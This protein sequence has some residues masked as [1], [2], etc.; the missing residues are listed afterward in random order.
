[1]LAPLLACALASVAAPESVPTFSARDVFELEYAADPRI[2]PDGT[3]IVYARTRLDIQT[4][5]PVSQLWMLE[6]RSG[7]HWPLTPVD[8]SCSS[9]R[10]S[11]DGKR[12]LYVANTGGG[13][14]LYLHWLERG[15]VSQ[16]TQLESSPG[17]LAWSPDGT[18]IAFSMEI[19]AP[20]APFVEMPKAPEG[21][22]WADP[23]R[24]IR[25]TQYK[26]DGSGLTEPAFRQLFV[27][28][29]EGG[30]PR[31][32]SEGPYDHT[33]VPSF[34]PDG[35]SLYCA[36][37]R[38][39]DAES[40]PLDSEIQRIDLIDGSIEALTSRLGPDDD[41]AVSPDGEWV[42][43]TGFDDAYQG[44]QIDQLYLMR[45]DGSE[46]RSLTHDL[47]RDVRGHRWSSSGDGI[48]FLYDDRG[49]T[50]LAFLEISGGKITLLADD[51]GGTSI[52][53]PYAS[54]SFTVSR[55][56]SAAYTRSTDQRPADVGLV[57]AGVQAKTLTDLNGDLLDNRRLGR[58]ES[59][60]FPSLADG[61]NIQGW[62]VF[63]PDY[64]PSESYPLILE[65]HGGPFANYG[66][67]FSAECQLYASAGYVVLYVN[68]RGSTSYGQEFGNLIH[69]AYPGEDYDDLMGGI[70][71]VI[72]NY[73]VD[74]ERLFV[75]G[76][77]GGG[78]LTSWIVGKT[79]RFQAAVVAKPV[80]HWTSF[81][82]TADFYTFFHRYWFPGP[83]WEHQEH[84]WKRSPLSLVGNV[85]TPT[86]LLT[87]EEDHRTPMSESEQYYQA[88]RLRGVESALVRVPGASHGIA[89]RP[90]HLIGKVL[91]ILKWFEIHDP[92][93]AEAR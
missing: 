12:L 13:A 80:I 79:D 65:I 82:L 69:H 92:E 78:V 59:I 40:Y 21:A 20:L 63:P 16:V 32:V 68:P 41:P 77:S 10:W 93:R 42:A 66:G 75:T 31:Q 86:M 24:L 8:S 43:Y 51:V 14:Q 25:H 30:T 26:Q 48:Y 91:H 90:S 87:G 64:D 72:A 67:R 23:P 1:M 88:L 5:R 55:N 74:P 58:V 70:E 9:P 19:P 34:S 84:Y 45:S 85:T 71:H 4:D 89:A 17:S 33:G 39:E 18:T 50:R 11:H 53:R 81:A 49:L 83:P 73:S 76:G 22:Q 52:G 36:A 37:N 6:V 2:S 44:Y 46:G 29:A 60:A 27:V 57:Q 3:R 54:G 35:R 7:E 56:G 61:R 28:P 15:T 38:R 62:L 47:D